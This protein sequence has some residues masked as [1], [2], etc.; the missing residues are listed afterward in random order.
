MRGC[1]PNHYCS[2]R[3]AGASTSRAGALV[4]ATT[5]Y[6]SPEQM[7]CKRGGQWACPYGGVANSVDASPSREQF[8]RLFI[9]DQRLIEV[10]PSSGHELQMSAAAIEA[11]Y[12]GKGG[13]VVEGM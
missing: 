12:G 7:A 3:P 4:F 5:V 10:D 1:T 9:F 11:L 8:A 2:A 6:V 13:Q